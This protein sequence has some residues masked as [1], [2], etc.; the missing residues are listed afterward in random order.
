[1]GKV[2]TDLFQIDGRNYLVMVDYFSNFIEIDFLPDTLAKTIIAKMKHHFA[3]H[4]IPDTVVSDG[5][6]QYN[7]ISKFQKELGICTRDVQP[8]K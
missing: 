7:Y 6:L 3:R 1:M 2:G 5:G 8:R 4:G